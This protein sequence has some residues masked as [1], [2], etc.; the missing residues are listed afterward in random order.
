VDV[1]FATGDPEPVP[2]P[3]PAAQLA[4][5]EKAVAAR[6]A[7]PGARFERAKAQFAAGNDQAAID[8]LTILAEKAPNVVGIYQWRS[9]AYARLGRAEE[10]RADV[11]RFQSLVESPTSGPYLEAVVAARLGDDREGLARLDAVVA[12]H[13]RDRWYLYDAAC[14]YAVAAQVTAERDSQRSHSLRQLAM[15][16]LLQA[17]GHGYDDFV[18]IRDEDDFN[19]LQELPAFRALLAQGHLER[20]YAAVFESS[21]EHVSQELH[22]LS[23]EEH[24]KRCRELVALGWRPAA[25]SL[26]RVSTPH[27]T[28]RLA[29][30]DQGGVLAASVWH[31][32]VV[33]PSEL[34][35]ICRR[36]SNAAAALL[37]LNQPQRVWPLLVHGADP[38]TRS[39]LV[40][41][42]APLGAAA[43]PLVERLLDASRPLAGHTAEQGERSVEGP[44]NPS[45]AERILFDRATSLRR[46][47]LLALGQ[48]DESQ[49]TPND[50]RRFLPW[51]LG[52]Y[53]HDPDAGV[54]SAA[55]WLL[56]HWGHE[57]QLVELE[58]RAVLQGPPTRDSSSPS[59]SARRWYVNGQGQTM[60]IVEGPVEFLMGSPAAEPGHDSDEALHR[61]RVGRSFAISAQEVT[62]AQFERWR[63]GFSLGSK[64]AVAGDCPVNLVTWYQ[65]AEYC[66]WLSEQEGLAPAEW[67]YLPNAENQYAEGMKP[68]EDYLTRRGYRL[69]SEAEWEFAARAGAVTSRFYGASEALLGEF[70]WFTNNSHNARLLE[71][72]RLKPNDLGL[73][74]VLGNVTEW[75][76]ERGRLFEG[77][78]EAPHTRLDIAADDLR[79]LAELKRTDLRALRG[80]AFSDVAADLRSANRIGGAPGDRE[81]NYGFRVARTHR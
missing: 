44:D 8:D 45:D 65:A 74:D 20:R 29:E 69:P 39:W 35:H 3:D 71:V 37:C 73:F 6:P 23:P 30:P 48:F 40:H 31:Q 5:A 22:G 51:L 18:H 49:L 58:A 52:I 17:V 34:E 57:R 11:K 28:A 14:A 72:G 64:H 47:L 27:G 55:G 32:S 12:Q 53:G 50:R 36:R 75:C 2:K 43:A 7:N 24:L 78:L 38:Q 10:A 16:L 9:Q 33:D 77:N 68:A 1:A 67:C 13:A 15:E 26:G 63:P 60:V 41:R 54:H 42:L 25:I 46:A 19:S 21:G 80:G 81:A 66:N 59:A 61:R 56:G 76:S 62:V 4:M 70:A 79:D